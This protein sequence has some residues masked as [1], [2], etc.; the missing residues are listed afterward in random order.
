MSGKSVGRF[1]QI[2]RDI[3]QTMSRRQHERSA[4][5][6]Q[7][8]SDEYGNKYFQQEG[9]SSKSIKKRRWVEAPDPDP[10]LLPRVPIEW[11][12]WLRKRRD[13]PPS[14]EEIARAAERLNRGKA[15]SAQDMSSDAIK[16]RVPTDA[17]APFPTYDDLKNRPIK[18][19]PD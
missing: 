4:A 11:D 17:K 1:S 10:M 12:S 6:V 7:V 16:D 14:T 2:F 13:E 8:G 15:M 19:K 9:D 3:R 5:K 18:N